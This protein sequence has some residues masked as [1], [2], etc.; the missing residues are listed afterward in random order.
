LSLLGELMVQGHLRFL[1]E[2][3]VFRGEDVPREGGVL[4]FDLMPDRDLSKIILD[5]KF[6]EATEEQ[7]RQISE[8]LMFD[9][10][11]FGPADVLV[12][13]LRQP[14]DQSPQ[15]IVNLIRSKWPP[16]FQPRH[17]KGEAGF[18]PLWFEKWCFEWA[19]VDV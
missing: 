9:S 13:G 7:R 16:E 17:R 5:G 2:T 10:E 12:G 14:S 15:A 18:D 11:V 3:Q 4:R 19:D 8:R 6:S 1:G